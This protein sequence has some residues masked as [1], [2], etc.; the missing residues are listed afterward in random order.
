MPNHPTETPTP[1]FSSA[2]LGAL[3][4]RLAATPE[5]II[6][7][8]RLRYRVFYRELAANPEVDALMVELDKDTY[9]D[10]AEHLLVFENET[11]I[12]TSRLIRNDTLPADKGFY[13]ESEFDI[14]GLRAEYPSGLL[15]IGR[16]CVEADNRRSAAMQVMWSGFAVYCFH[17]NIGALFGCGSFHSSDIEEHRYALAWMHKHHLAPAAWRPRVINE[18]FTPI[19]AELLPAEHAAR[20]A[21][22]ADARRPKLPSLIKGYLRLGGMIG[23]GAFLDHQF[24]TTDICIIVP[25]AA[26]SE[27]YLQH[28]TKAHGN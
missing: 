25:R 22:Q 26:V 2:Q 28:Y 21:C 10:Y 18:H 7:A 15:E 16:T 3:S 11:L 4:V 24:N 8:Q 20:A 12:A 13:T 9:D 1:D 19:D 14:S 23:D 6:E 5:E 17:H 27:R